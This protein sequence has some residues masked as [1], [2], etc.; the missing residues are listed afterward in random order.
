MIKF[1]SVTL[2]GFK[3]FVDKTELT[4]APGLTG[5]VGPNGCGKSNLVEGLRWAM[6]ESSAKRM[7]GGDMDDVIFNGTS[8]RPARNFAEVVIT[9]NNGMHTAPEPYAPYDQIE[10]SRRIERENGSTYRVNGK[11]A[12]ARDVQ[13]LL[14]DT[15]TG[16]NSPALVSQGKLTQI[17]TAKPFD[18]RLILEESAGIT[19]LHARRHEAELRL[20]AADNNLA[21]LQDSLG[22][23]ETQ[24]TTLKRQSRQA[25]KYR[26]ITDEIKQL[27][28]VIAALDWYKI[29]HQNQQDR[30]AF[31]RIEQT[32]ADALLSVTQLTQT[33]D[34]QTVEL[35]SLRN[36]AAESGARLQAV[37]IE[38][39][40]LE[41][42]K[43]QIQESITQAQAGLSQIDQDL[44]HDQ[45]LIADGQGLM[46]ALF[47]EE[48]QLQIE[49]EQNDGRLPVLE[50]TRDAIAMKLDRDSK[51][52]QSKTQTLMGIDAK[53]QSLINQIKSDETRLESNR[54][55]SDQTRARLSLFMN[56]QS[57]ETSDDLES[58]IKTYEATLQT[59]Q[60]L[61]TDLK[62]KT[63]NAETAL[64]AA[65]AARDEKRQMVITYQTER[66]TLETFLSQDDMNYTPVLA[67]IQAEAGFE[68][69]LA[70]ALGDTLFGSMDEQASIVWRGHERI[71]PPAFPTGV[72]PL[73]EKVKAPPA[74]HAALG[75]IGYVSDRESGD[76]A[77]TFLAPGQTIV[78]LD[79]YLWRW[80]GLF[81]KPSVKD[82]Q[83]MILEHKNRLATVIENLERAEIN[84]SAAEN[85]FLQSDITLTSV[86][87][88]EQENDSALRSTQSILNAARQEFQRKLQS[89]QASATEYARLTELL[90]LIEQDNAER[91]L[92]LDEL[93]QDL[94]LLPDPVISGLASDV[95]TL[96]D[97]VNAAQIELRDATLAVDRFLQ[98][99]SR[100]KARFHGI[101]DQRV[102]LNN[103]TARAQDHLNQL[104]DRRI[105]MNEKLESLI[106]KP[107]DLS[108]TMNILMSRSSDLDAQ[109]KIDSDALQLAEN[110]VI[111]LQR[112]LKESESILA[113]SREERAGIQGRIEMQAERLTAIESEILSLFQLSPQQLFESA[114]L[115]FDTA[116]NDLL[117]IDQKRSRKEKLARDRDA[118]GPVNLRAD[119][120]AQEIEITLNTINSER[121]DLIKAINEL[122]GAI[123]TI[124]IEARDRLT[125][126][127]D[128]INTHFKDL[129]TRLF[130]GGAAHLQLIEANNDPLSAGLEIFA[131]PPGKTLQS[132][133][134]LSGGEQS[135]TAA[136]LIFAMFLTNPSPICV[137]DEIDAPLDDANVDR[138][139]HL[140]RHITDICGTRF[141]VV[142]HH[143][144]TMAKMDRLYGVT[145]GEKGVSQLVSVDLQQKLDFLEAA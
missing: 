80:D 101:A 73:D 6:G 99:S 54:A 39:R 108:E 55:R 32:V 41:N 117:S 135:L 48:K 104:G 114:N 136:A 141:L 60:N 142:T 86:R 14:A 76:G 98:D 79:G 62:A 134:L 116:E 75:Y 57:A 19:G 125:T 25:E 53:R 58:Q 119:V 103:R 85:T 5:I 110:T 52:L 11:I 59:L 127:F 115:S 67:D 113:Q 35:P 56:A 90:N 68:T 27:E 61:V 94:S 33:L 16:A 37:T 123:H 13:L 36:K 29:V 92:A 107:T 49:E 69:A 120:E 109:K 137:L 89:D 132:I 126:A 46:A 23:L 22:A 81:I 40:T 112:S 28:S 18:R 144:L 78:S 38:L 83:A 42:E 87:I 4:I 118:I 43:K 30:H 72:A 124:N 131:Q 102:S 106:A 105:Q 3:S 65:R 140:L 70:K 17:I 91:A 96:R 128:T 47:S 139:C 111:T 1:E 20:Q 9:L 130:G 15:M 26:V 8:T 121:D 24:L 100:R 74:L 84:L 82:R 12:R 97:H 64:N 129:F 122:R 21:R 66:K 71:S 10:I 50:Q 143:R 95:S 93:K 7:R 31:M 44:A 77:S 45:Q 88:S 63:K 34:S 51:E 138:I 145:M 2:S 133:S